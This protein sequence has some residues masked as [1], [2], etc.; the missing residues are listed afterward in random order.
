[1]RHEPGTTKEQGGSHAK[2]PEAE[3]VYLIQRLVEEQIV[4]LDNLYE[5]LEG[6]DPATLTVQ[7]RTQATAAVTASL[8]AVSLAVNHVSGQVDY[9]GPSLINT[10]SNALYQYVQKVL[11]LLPALRLRGMEVSFTASA[12]PAA[13]LTLSLEP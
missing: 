11:L 5:R 9:F 3:A 2:L 1:M 7:E 12:P 4:T 6:R 10:I 8:M 13:S